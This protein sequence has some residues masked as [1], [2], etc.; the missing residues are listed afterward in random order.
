[1]TALILASIFLYMLVDG[2]DLFEVSTGKRILPHKSLG[3]ANCVFGT[4]SV[5]LMGNIASGSGGYEARN[6]M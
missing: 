2:T 4:L 3:I 1:M 5:S 6:C